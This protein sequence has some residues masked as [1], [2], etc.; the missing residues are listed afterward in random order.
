MQL[1]SV[2]RCVEL[3]SNEGEVI[4]DPFSGVGTTVFVSVANKR[5]AIGI[6]LKTFYHNQAIK[7]VNRLKNAK[8]LELF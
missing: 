7:N 3:W 4:L 2:R 1:E 5:K 8:Q 6:E